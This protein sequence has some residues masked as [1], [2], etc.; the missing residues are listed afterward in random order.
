MVSTEKRTFSEAAR[1]CNKTY[2]GSLA[3]ISNEPEHSLLI[4]MIDDDEAYWIGLKSD[5]VG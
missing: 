4:S 3:S 1:Y 2:G 5:G